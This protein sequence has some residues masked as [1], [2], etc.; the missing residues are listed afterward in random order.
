[1]IFGNAILAF[2][3]LMCLANLV[4]GAL[5]HARKTLLDAIHRRR[6]NQLRAMLDREGRQDKNGHDGKLDNDTDQGSM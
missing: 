1:M 5:P 2:A 4:H 3:F 6:M